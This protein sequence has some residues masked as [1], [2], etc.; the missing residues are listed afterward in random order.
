MDKIDRQ[1]AALLQLDARMPNAEIGKAVGVSVSTASE[2]VR[3]LSAD[4]HLTAVRGILDPTAFGLG[5]SAFLFVDMTYEGEVAACEAL[6]ERPEIQ[7]IHH[8]SGSHSY[9]VKVR[10]ADTAH[11]QR[12]LTNDIKPLAAVVRTET[13]VVLETLKETT[14]IALSKTD[15]L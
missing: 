6:A 15:A 7:E 11:L 5:L 10:V 1:I 14:T 4:G 8:V 2:R 13:L 12:L 9:L 3:R